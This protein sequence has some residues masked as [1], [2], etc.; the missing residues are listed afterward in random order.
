[1]YKK[2]T[3]NSLLEELKNSIH[4]RGK[5]NKPFQEWDQELLDAIVAEGLVD[6]AI[7]LI[8]SLD[9]EGDWEQV[10]KRLAQPKVKKLRWTGILKYAAIFL[11]L[12]SL[13]LTFIWI[14]DGSK[15]MPSIEEG[16]FVVLDTGSGSKLMADHENHAITLSSGETV[17]M[18]YGDTL[19]YNANTRIDDSVFNELH[20]PNGKTFTLV[21]SD[22]TAIQL[23]SGSNI[24]FPA[25]FPNKG[26][27]E[28]YV[29]GE[30]YFDVTKDSEHPFIVNSEEVSVKVLGTEFNFSSYKEQ[31]EVSTVLVEGS[32]MLNH[33][34]SFK[35]NVTLAP[36]EKG[37]WDRSKGIIEVKGVDTNLYVGWMKG[38]IVFRDTS[39]REL[40]ASLERVY[41]VEI[42]NTN[43]EIEKQNFTARFNRNVERV[44]DVL[45]A[46]KVIVPFSYK[47]TKDKANKN[48]II[49]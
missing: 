10:S 20:I 38:E 8:E 43:E 17:A 4:K 6:E 25:K 42:E 34:G 9:V 21:L 41:N 14:Y 30:A 26:N 1:M 31:N 49:S 45:E 44:E 7:S 12:I 37:S 46:L 2:G 32:V 23:N 22:G 24:K 40:L 35:K 18:H 48:I 16:N 13:G 11:G 33:G 28:V 3:V 36:G 29:Y 5:S 27:R 39:F 19:I 47:V 15:A